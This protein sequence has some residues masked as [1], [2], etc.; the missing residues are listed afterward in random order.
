MGSMHSRALRYFGIFFGALI[1]AAIGAR[2][3]E[4]APLNA[5]P[6]CV[7]SNLSFSSGAQICVQKNL[8]MTCAIDGDR[9]QWILVSDKALSER[10]LGPSPRK[11]AE[12]GVPVHRHVIRQV[13]PRSDAALVPT[14][15]PC[16]TFNGRRFC[17]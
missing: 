3:T 14:S 16:F 7:Y 1:A 17:E 4:A 5:G 2:P 8:M 10:C 13:A 11:I 6:V 12:V 9:P 15:A